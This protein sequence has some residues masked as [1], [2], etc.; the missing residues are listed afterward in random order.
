[1]I[2]LGISI[3]WLALLQVTIVT[4]VAAAAIA[5]LV[6]LSNWAFTPAGGAEQPTRSRK[7]LGIV[8]LG[9]VG[10]I[11]LFGLYLMIPYFH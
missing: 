5:T 4:I 2:S 11:I 9:L 1:M 10:L 6:S 7:V 8:F 3:D